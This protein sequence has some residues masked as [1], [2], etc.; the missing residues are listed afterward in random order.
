MVLAILDCEK[1]SVSAP[2]IGIIRPCGLQPPPANIVNIEKF[3]ADI[4]LVDS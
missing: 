3:I 4:M 1:G 2:I